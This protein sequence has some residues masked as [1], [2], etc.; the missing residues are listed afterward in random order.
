MDGET[1]HQGAVRRNQIRP[2]RHARPRLHRLF[3]RRRSC[4]IRR[5]AVRKGDADGHMLFPTMM[6]RVNGVD[7]EAAGEA[8]RTIPALME[9]AEKRGV[10][11]PRKGAIVRPQ[12]HTNEWRVN[13]TQV[14][15]AGRP[16]RRRHRRARTERRRNRRPASGARFLRIPASARRPVLPTPI[17]STFRRSSASAKRAASP[18]AISSPPTTSSP[19]PAFPDTIGVNGWPIENHVAGD[20]VWRWPDIPG[21]RGFNHLPY[22]MLVPRARFDNLLV[23]GRCASMTMKG[24]RRRASAGAC[25]VMGQAAGTAAHLTLAGNARRADIPVRDAARNLARRRRLSRARRRPEAN[26]T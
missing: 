2:R 25:F 24:N 11:F 14:K 1:P 6:F 20:V 10:K 8:W 19:A 22:R 3:R 16:R 15:N 12:K 5:R 26:K 13:V 17:S 23:A 21:S 9:E 7:A 18:A 4:R